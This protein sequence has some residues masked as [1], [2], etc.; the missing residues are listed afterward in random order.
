MYYLTKI[1]YLGFFSNEKLKWILPL[2]AEKHIDPM[3]L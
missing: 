2:N 3:A 1:S